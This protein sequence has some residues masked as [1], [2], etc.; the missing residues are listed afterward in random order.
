MGAVVYR[1]APVVIKNQPK[2]K[3]VLAQSTQFQKKRFLPIILVTIGSMLI[4]NV[5]WPI[6]SYQIL[7]SPSL[8]VKTVISPLSDENTLKYTPSLASDVVVPKVSAKNEEEKL[9]LKEGPEIISEELDYTN[10]SNWFSNAS[11]PEGSTEEKVSYTLDIPALKLKNLKVII[12]ESDL[13]KGLIQYPGTAN[14]GELG[15][16]VIF[17]HSTNP[18]FYSPQENNPKRY[19]SVFTKL[20]DLKKDDKIYIT[21]DGI[22]YVYRVMDK[23][24]VKPDD[25]YI[26]QQRHDTRELKLVTCTPVGTYLRR[27]VILAQL[28]DIQ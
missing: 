1:K 10:L 17:G 12:G 15:D 5:S 26:L 14:P 2:E 18:L 13:S 25:T 8:Q 9:V 20:M 4:A 11:I 3:K 16:P 23:L 22:K 28:D 19:M 21:Y 24:E 7:T 27:G 6:I